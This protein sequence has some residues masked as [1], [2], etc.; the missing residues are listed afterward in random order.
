MQLAVLVIAGAA[1]VSLLTNHVS[2]TNAVTAT[3][4]LFVA[5]VRLARGKD[6]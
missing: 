6:T 4:A 2:P 3:I 5:L 1:L